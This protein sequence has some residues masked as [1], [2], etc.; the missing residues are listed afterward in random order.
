MLLS[1][2]GAVVALAA[3][4]IGLSKGGLGGGIGPFITILTS[5][6][7][8]PTVALG[9]L[10]PMLMATD[11]VALYA[12]RGSWNRDDLVR[13]VPPA[14]VAIF[15]TSLFLGSLSEDAV[16]WFLAAFSLLFVA[17]R[18]LGDRLGL[19]DREAG[20]TFGVV[21]GFVSGVTSTAAHA[22][23]PP[24]AAYLLA[25]KIEPLTY[26]GT[27]AVFFF[28]VNWLKVPGYALNGFFD[29]DL[30][31]EMI[32]AATAALPGVF[33]GRWLVERIDRTQFERLILFGLVVGAAVLVLK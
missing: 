12:L 11:V 19:T 30:I 26:A 6:A 23:G 22:G 21:A 29:F 16:R 18:L 17:Y 27:S 20:R 14:A 13:L 15:C 32:P 33:L 4:L 8:P 25:R 10:L 3:F 31:V 7:L 1:H 5:L 28:V 24:V 2:V 9:L